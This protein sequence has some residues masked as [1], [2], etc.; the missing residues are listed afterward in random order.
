MTRI[1]SSDTNALQSKLKVP[2]SELTFHALIGK[3][4]FKQVGTGKQGTRRRDE[5]RLQAP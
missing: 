5:S 1:P 3:G 2:F 4:S